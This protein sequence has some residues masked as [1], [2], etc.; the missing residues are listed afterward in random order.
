MLF[1]TSLNKNT[2]CKYR[3]EYGSNTAVYSNCNAAHIIM[4]SNVNAT[5][6][7]CHSLLDV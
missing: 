2:E 3:I 1:L 5:E 6:T 4:M 7:D